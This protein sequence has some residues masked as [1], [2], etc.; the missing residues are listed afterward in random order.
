MNTLEL[1]QKGREIFSDPDAWCQFEGA[2]DK[3]GNCVEIDDKHA[4]C[5]CSDGIIHYLA[6]DHRVRD[7]AIS[8]LECA[9][10]QLPDYSLEVND[11]N[12]ENMKLIAFN[13]SN[14]YDLVMQAWDVAIESLRE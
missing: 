4:V 7:E 13:D 14:D 11:H 12:P 1:L 10:D 8:A 2:M 9:I 5:W 3:D 6:E